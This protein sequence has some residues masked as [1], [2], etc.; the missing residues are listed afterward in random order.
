MTG[1]RCGVTDL[2]VY[3]CVH[4]WPYPPIPVEAES[5]DPRA[6]DPAQCPTCGCLIRARDPIGEMDG[7]WVC[8]G[9]AP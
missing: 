7:T 2:L 6:Q 1:E 5:A 9:C 8:E 4:C 3:Q